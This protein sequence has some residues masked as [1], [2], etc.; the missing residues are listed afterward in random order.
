MAF[1][2]SINMLSFQIDQ[3]SPN[4]VTIARPLLQ[5]IHSRIMQPSKQPALES[6][7]LIDYTREDRE[8][9]R[10]MIR[11]EGLYKMQWPT[12][13]N[14]LTHGQRVRLLAFACALLGCD[15]EHKK[16]KQL[17]AQ[18]MRS[19]SNKELKTLLD[20]S[21]KLQSRSVVLFGQ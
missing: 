7:P 8:R 13:R 14:D 4:P 6:V 3:H 20:Y 17:A 5:K 12:N 1:T 10:E 2:S 15:D 21:E 19:G 18:M 9:C 16:W 11:D